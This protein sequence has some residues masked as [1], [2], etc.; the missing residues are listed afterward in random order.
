MTT[1]RIYMH[2]DGCCIGDASLWKT[3]EQV[4]G[5]D[6]QP[7]VAFGDVRGVVYLCNH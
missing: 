4:E 2:K 3:D 1:F 7:Q 6:S 5:E